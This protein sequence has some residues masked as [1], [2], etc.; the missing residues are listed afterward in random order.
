MK[1]FNTDVVVIGCA[2]SEL[3]GPALDRRVIDVGAIVLTRPGRTG[4]APE[5]R[6]R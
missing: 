3:G 6:R 1:S 2:S 4:A 5:R